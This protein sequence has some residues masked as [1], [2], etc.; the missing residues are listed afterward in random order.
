[1]FSPSQFLQI[2]STSHAEGGFVVYALDTF[3][4]VWK[5]EE[6]QN[7]WVRLPPVL[8]EERDPKTNSSKI[9]PLVSITAARNQHGEAQLFGLGRTGTVWRF[10]GDGW[11]PVTDTREDLE[12]QRI[13]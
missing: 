13:P 4:F 12:A 5:R 8:R 3:N 7:E 10:D 11:S 6:H 9:D 1:M 2:T